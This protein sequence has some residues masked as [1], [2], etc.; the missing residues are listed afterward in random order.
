[1]PVLM[2]FEIDMTVF[3]S[4]NLGFG[5]RKYR[6]RGS[7]C[8]FNQFGRLEYLIKYRY[9]FFIV[10]APPGP[11]VRRARPHCCGRPNHIVCAWSLVR[12]W[13]LERVCVGCSFAVEGDPPAPLLAALGLFTALGPFPPLGPLSACAW[14]VRSQWGDIPQLTCPLRSASLLW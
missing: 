4:L 8:I 6:D 11:P 13:P 9:L 2:F 10:G 12:A 5:T 7:R 3:S 1:M 14:G